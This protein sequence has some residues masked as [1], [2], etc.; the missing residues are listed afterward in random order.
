MK[1]SRLRPPGMIAVPLC[2]A[3]L[4]AAASLEQRSPPPKLVVVLVVDQ[5][6]A[7]YLQKY[8]GGFTGGLRRLTR[9]GAWFT[10]AA[11]PYLNTVTCAGHSTIG[12]GTFPYHHGMILNGWL[13]RQTGKSPYCTDDPTVQELSYNG[14]QGVQGD[15]AKRMLVPALGEQIRERGRGRAVALSLKPRSSIP[16]VGHS[17]DAVVWFDDRGG[18]STSSAFTPGLVPFVQQFIA[19]NP[20]AADYDKVWDRTL[21]PSA[22]QGE[23]DVAAERPPEGTTRTFPHILGTPGGRPDVMFYGRWQR[24]PYSDEY[25]GRMAATAVDALKLGTDTGIDY[26]AVSFSALDL[27]GHVF[28]PRSQEVQ[29]VIV[30]LDLTIGRLLEHLD[31]QVGAGKYV[32]ALSAD[33]G[34][35]EIPEQTAHA[36][37]QAAKEVRDALAKV[38]VPALGSGE[39]VLSSAYTDIY[40]EPNALARMR[41]N[42]ELTSAVLDALKKLPGIS[43]AFLGEDLTKPQARESKDPVRRAAALSYYPGRSG[44]LII[45]PKENWLMSSNVTTHGTLYPYDQRVPVI[46]FGASVRAGQYPQAATPA[47]IAPTLA[48]V[49]QV[50]IAKTDGRVLTEALVNDGDGQ[51]RDPRRPEA[52]R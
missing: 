3:L 49:A 18:W 36:G 42:P 19:A 47:D 32:L 30:R 6:R 51:G 26:L 22:Y 41:R 29:D 5:M 43:Q 11:Y 31:R 13:D 21:P 46:F 1:R 28:G 24:S 50:R 44:D 10:N 20:I 25:L 4:G 15:S 45:V 9:D 23:D 12:T 52:A 8:G 34:V 14:L 2:A 39:H 27:V 16:L 35:A 48:A 17:A 33:H 37:R 40:L 7:D 38:L